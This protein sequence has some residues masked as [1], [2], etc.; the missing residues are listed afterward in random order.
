MNKEARANVLRIRSTENTMP[1]PNYEIPAGTII[2]CDSM[3][4]SGI[5]YIEQK[6]YIPIL[7]NVVKG[8]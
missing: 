8:K 1:N 2:Y 4:I 3:I 6:H 5:K 7:N